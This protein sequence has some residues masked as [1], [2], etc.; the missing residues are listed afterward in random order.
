MGAAARAMTDSYLVDGVYVEHGVPTEPVAGRPPLL[1]VHGGGHGAWCWRLWLDA[2]PGLGWEACALSF[3]NHP[4]SRTVERAAYLAQTTVD[5]YADDVAAVAAHLGRPVV[6]VGHSTGGIVAQRLTARHRSGDPTVQALVL[7]AS[8]PPG[9]LGPVRSVAFPLEQG[10]RHDDDT[11]ARTFFHSAP[12]E[13]V[14]W[15]VAHWAVAQLVDESPNVINSFSLGAGIAIDP[16]AV[17]CPVLSVTAGHDG[18]PMP[19]DGRIAAH[20]GG[21]HWH[22][23]EHG[24]NLMLE[25]HWEELLGRILRWVDDH[26]QG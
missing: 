16:A 21:T 7:L 25:A 3:R 10:M 24:H 23:A 26:G 9:Q 13:T 22:E 8:V 2:L 1:L 4:G 17:S 11:A 18:T 6:L 19:R 5:D 20:Y 15:A 14:R 12:P